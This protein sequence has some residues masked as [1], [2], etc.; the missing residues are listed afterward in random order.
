VDCDN[1]ILKLKEHEGKELFRRFGVPTTDGYLVARV[2]DLRQVASPVVVK[3]QVQVGG[4]GKAGGIRFASTDDQL[5]RAVSD[6]IGMEIGGQK[7]S[8]VLIE[9]RVSVDREIYLSIFLDRGTRLPRLMII[10]EGGMDVESADPSMIL[11]WSLN[12]FIGM[13]DYIAREAALEIILD[14]GPAA[15]LAEVL[16]KAWEMFWQM[17]CELLEINPLVR[18]HDGRM[19]AIDAKVVL[20]DD[21]AFR[22][23]EIP[24]EVGG[25][26]LEAEARS[27][28]LSLVQLDGDVGVIANGAGLTM[29]TLDVLAL[30]GAKGGVF[31][32]LGGTDDKEVVQDALALVAKAKP[33][34]ALVNIFGGITKCDTVAEGIIEAKRA[35][36]LDFDLV[37]RVRGVNEA[38]A[39]KMLQE[40]GIR[41]MHELDEACAEAAR[42]RRG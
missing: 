17:D 24:M 28:G 31:L 11:S 38:R 20:D 30:H 40:N 4:R 42:S 6:V 19:L 32:D 37:I 10:K 9:E 1:E 25:T 15:Q 33:R 16:K 12:P 13:P 29:A 2:E 36:Q 21:A 34:V 39:K 26:S 41:A 14:T 22:H 3:A 35:L 27:K 7:V 23:P 8:E 18:T 5:R